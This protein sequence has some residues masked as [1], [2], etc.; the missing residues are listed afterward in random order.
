[1]FFLML[2]HRFKTFCLV[3]SF[4][5]HEQGKAIVKNMTKN[6]VFYAF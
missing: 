5:G 6:F 2:D 1:M 3:F 4:V